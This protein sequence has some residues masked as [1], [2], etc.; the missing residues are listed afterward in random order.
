MELCLGIGREN[1]TP[2][3]GTALYGY[4]PDHFSTAVNDDLT[5]TALYL[6]QGETAALILSVT[7]GTL[8][9]GLAEEIS[10]EIEKKFEI[11]RSAQL[12]HAIHTHSAPNTTGTYGWGDIDREYVDEIMMPGIYGAVESAVKGAVPALMSASSGRSLVGINRRMLT[13]DNEIRLGQNTWG[14]FDPTMTVL[15]FKGI[16]GTPLANVIH[17]GAHATASGPNREITRD[18]PGVMIDTLEKE[19]GA[20]TMFING[21]EG[22]VGP[23]LTNGRTTG[24]GNISYALRLG[25]VAGQDAVEIYNTR[26][27][28]SVPGLKAVG[29]KMVLPLT[30]RIPLEEAKAEHKKYE[31]ETVNNKAQLEKYY[32][33]VIESYE[34]GYEERKVREVGQNIIMLG[35]VAIVAFPYE[36]FSEIGLRIRRGAEI[37]HVLCLSNTN[38]SEGYFATESEI[39]RGGY[40]I[41]MSRSSNIQNFTDDAD[42]YAV[43]ETLKNLKSLEE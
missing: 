29:A 3:V 20:V 7:V 2:K 12:L 22:D 23:R 37:R 32:R 35:D 21:P 9:N 5:A 4:T 41:K 43:T 15:S 31:G 36:L 17:Y 13:L 1:I 40:E 42:W 33:E 39:C 27:A 26:G 38:G 8:S 19:S 25:A 11:P 6:R 34:D 30:S 28:Y 24:G 10:K 14:P 16:D 18:W